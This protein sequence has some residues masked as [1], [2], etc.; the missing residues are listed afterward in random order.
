MNN[1]SNTNEMEERKKSA[2][3]EKETK[4]TSDSILEQI[5]IYI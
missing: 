1:W 5:N 3:T 2:R 4:T